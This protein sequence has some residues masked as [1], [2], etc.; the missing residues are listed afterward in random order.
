M[1]KSLIFFKFIMSRTKGSL[2]S[3]HTFQMATEGEKMYLRLLTFSLG[4][5]MDVL[6]LF[7]ETK[8]L[9]GFKFYMFLNQHKHVLFHQFIPKV[10]CCECKSISLAAPGRCQYMNTSQFYTL[11][12]R[13][14]QIATGHEHK[15]C[16]GCL[17]EHCLCQY[18]ASKKVSVDCMDIS[19]MHVVIKTC[20]PV[21]SI[22]GDH[23][24]LTKIKDIRNV[25]AHPASCSKDINELNDQWK[26]LEDNV[27]KYADVIASTYQ[28]KVKTEIHALK[29]DTPLDH[30]QD[31]V[32]HSS[33][34][35]QEVCFCFIYQ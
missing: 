30:L 14:G 16:K 18:S 2:S 20:C 1:F 25:L 29:E 32:K 33:E 26:T 23:N 7:F 24:W 19:L 11:Y 5:T 10:P 4:P 12:E 35:I 17:K 3:F 22:P 27:L 15:D 6:H 8:V 9:K 31:V 13:T 21:G 28:K 34:S